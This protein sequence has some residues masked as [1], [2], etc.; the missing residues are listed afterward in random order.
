VSCS[1]PKSYH[2]DFHTELTQVPHTVLL[3]IL[4]CCSASQLEYFETH[5]DTTKL[6]IQELNAL[7]K[8]LYTTRWGQKSVLSTFEMKPRQQQ[9][10]SVHWWRQKYWERHVAECI[11]CIVEKNYESI[12]KPLGEVIKMVYIS[13]SK[14]LQMPKNVPTVLSE[15]IKM[16]GDHVQ[17]LSLTNQTLSVVVNKV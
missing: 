1:Q 2:T 5:F 14:K 17:M 10:T 15:V 13:K 6:N 8:E 11:K 7:W 9:E 12:N 4:A 16:Y 3:S